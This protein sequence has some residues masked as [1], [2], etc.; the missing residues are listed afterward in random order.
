[1]GS[2]KETEEMKDLCMFSKVCK[3]YRDD[4]YTCCHD[5]E[6]KWYCGYYKQHLYFQMI[7]GMDKLLEGCDFI[8]LGEK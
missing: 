8:N 4:A 7:A 3:G 2:Q 6:A 5:T 1:L